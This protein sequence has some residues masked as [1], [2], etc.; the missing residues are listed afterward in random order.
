MNGDNFENTPRVDADIFIRIKKCVFK[1]I[2]I[3]VDGVLD[4]PHVQGKSMPVFFFKKR[5][6]GAFLRTN[7]NTY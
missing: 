1:N 4:L 7:V 3:C 2:R 5:Q 6:S